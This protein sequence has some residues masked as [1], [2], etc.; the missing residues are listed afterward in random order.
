MEKF[1]IDDF[2]LEQVTNLPEQK[3]GNGWTIE[4]P[5]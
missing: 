4:P 2:C 1:S 3:E 5:K